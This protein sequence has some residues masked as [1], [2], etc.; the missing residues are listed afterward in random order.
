MLEDESGRLRLTGNIL[1]TTHLVTGVIIAVLGTEN[2][3]GD[4]EI[5][6]TKLPDFPPQPA[7]W[8]L[9]PTDKLKSLLNHGQDESPEIKSPKKIAFV[10]GLGITGSS[11]DLTLELL[12]DYL[13]GYSDNLDMENDSS[14]SSI[15]RLIIAG[16]SLRDPESSTA[17]QGDDDDR[18]MKKKQVKKYGYD[19]T[20]YNASPITHLDSFLAEILPSIPITI[21]PGE[22][23]PANIALPQQAIHP[24]MFP[25]ARAYCSDPQQAD[26]NADPGWFD[27]VTNPWEGYVEGWR[28]WGCSGQN[29]DDILRYLEFSDE[30]VGLGNDAEADGTRLRVLEALLRWRCAV[31][32]AP[33]TL[34]KFFFKFLIRSNYR[35]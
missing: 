18:T 20:S 7:R 28:V 10:S 26:T 27:N 21:L 23:D 34:C 5:I 29:V 9:S 6:D 22:T 16:N 12:T 17:G 15:C 2:S 8:E 3:N 14:A 33:D 4:F 25:Q 19:A 32:T 35:N 24:A 13:L 31:P 11:S 30:D 1:R